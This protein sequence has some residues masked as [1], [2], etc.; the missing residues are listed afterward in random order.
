[1]TSP[2][3][4]MQN[5]LAEPFPPLSSPP[6]PQSPTTE[7]AHPNRSRQTSST[8]TIQGRLRS[9]SKNFQESNPPTGMCIA[10]AGI[11]SSVPSLSDIRRG[12]Y[13]SDGWSGEGQIREKE[14]RASLSTRGGPQ[15]GEERR[16]SVNPH[17]PKETS[18][19]F[20]HDSVPEAV[21]ET[22]QHELGFV[23]GAR[24]TLQTTKSA[25]K[26]MEM[27]PRVEKQTSGD[28][29]SSSD[30]KISPAANT[31]S[32]FMTT[33]FDNGYQFPP[34][35][36][37]IESTAIFLTAFWKFFITPVGFLVTVYGLNVVAWG[38][39]LFLLLCN[40][41]PAMC[42]PTCNDINS[43]RRI[44]IEIDSQILNALFCVT[45]FGTIPWRF[46]DLYYLL[47]YRIQKNEMGL[48]RLA[49]INRGWFR[50]AGSQDLPVNLGP[51]EIETEISNVSED[52][53]P[54]PITKIPNAPLTGVR[55]PPTAMWKLDFVVWTMVWNTF[56][57]AV[58]SGFMWGLNRYRRPSWSTGLFVALACIVAACGGI[59]AFVEG[60][61]VKSIEGVPVSEKDQE[62][63]KR[64]RE[65]GITHYNNIKDQPPKEKKE[66]RE[67]GIFKRKQKI[68]DVAEVE[69]SGLETGAEQAVR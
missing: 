55:A 59:M 17:S 68:A 30:T 44:W 38:G 62:R 61:H 66:R 8:S 5:D 15:A 51:G 23:S 43:P 41:S 53:I 18:H 33:P 13:N 19:Q 39:M 22:D 56:L 60:K 46:R 49:G 57:Q 48:R 7:Q 52:R 34:K 26:P 32:Q 36:S 67:G 69:E 45:G 65:Q 1:M 6:S 50:L 37:W 20:R 64:D 3:T 35:H 10:T 12:S 24:G 27:D 2:R 25:L 4:T 9:A 14:R 40:A 21:E 42:K 63:L 54:F 28:Q 29:R 47:Q 58:L 31:E 16:A 11:A